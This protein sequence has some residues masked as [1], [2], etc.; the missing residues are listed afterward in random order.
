MSG[1]LCRPRDPVDLAEKIARMAGLSPAEREAMGKRGREKVE[2]EFDER[3]VIGKYL[4]AIAS[5]VRREK[6][7]FAGR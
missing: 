3:I 6:L 1:Y 4:K 5:V 2:R 7:A